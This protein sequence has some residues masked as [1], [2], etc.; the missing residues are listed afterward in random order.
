M[1]PRMIDLEG[2]RNRGITHSVQQICRWMAA[3]KFPKAAMLGRK[4]AWVESEVDA[5]LAARIA[6]RDQEIKAA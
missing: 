3:G 6:A 4:R 1:A 2:L 5:W